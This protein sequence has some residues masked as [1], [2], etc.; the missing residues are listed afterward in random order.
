M[1]R[2]FFSPSGECAGSRKPWLLAAHSMGRRVY[3]TNHA[4][5]PRQMRDMVTHDVTQAYENA[6]LITRPCHAE[7]LTAA[8]LYDKVYI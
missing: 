2:G 1:D 4:Q 3:P 8:I 7:L 6:F 5:K